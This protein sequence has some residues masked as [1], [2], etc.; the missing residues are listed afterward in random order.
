MRNRVER[1]GGAFFSDVRFRAQNPC[2]MVVCV[3]LA[4]LCLGSCAQEASISFSAM[5]TVVTVRSFGRRPGAAN[6]CLR[7]RVLQ[8]EEEISVTNESGEVYRL[9]HSDARRADVSEDT[10]RLMAFSLKMAEETDGAFN[11]CLYPITSAWGFTTGGFR[12]PAD[13]EIERLL[14]LVDFSKARVEGQTIFLEHGGAD[15]GRMMVDFGAVGKGFASDEAVRILKRAG[16]RS[17]VIDFGGN[18]HA[19]GQ[20][21][22][23]RGRQSDWLIGVANPFSDGVACAVRVRDKAVVTS[24]GYE[25]FFEDECGNRHSHIFDGKT[26][27]PARS[28]IASATVVADSGL[29]ADALST[30]LFVLGKNRAVD[31]WRDRRDFEMILILEENTVLVSEGL[32]DVFTQ[33]APFVAVEVVRAE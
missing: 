1:S 21:R 28:G 22:G 17:A 18:V 4:S 30:S 10:A 23:A 25:R 29:Y 31:L 3:L 14:P 16:V 8:I 32:K 6:E 27:K 5:D 20:K 9:N 33:V 12:V 2:A 19:L 13:S 15:G 7:E 24:G 11:P 26:G